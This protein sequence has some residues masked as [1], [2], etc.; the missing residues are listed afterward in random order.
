M[1]SSEYASYSSVLTFPLL[2]FAFTEE[3][4]YEWINLRSIIIR[5][6][7]TPKCKPKRQRRLNSLFLNPSNSFTIGSIPIDLLIKPRHYITVTLKVHVIESSF[8]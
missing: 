4:S 2:E 5:S 7:G 3:R 8:L 6:C 1:I